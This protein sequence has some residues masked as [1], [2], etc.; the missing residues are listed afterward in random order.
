MTI[1]GKMFR[2]VWLCVLL[3]LC[4][5]PMVCSAQ[6]Y[7]DEDWI[8][9]VYNEDNGLPTG[10]ANA[11]VQTSDGYVWIGSYGGLIRFDGKEFLNF[12]ARK[13]LNSSSI[14][15]LYE[16]KNGILYIGTNDMGVYLY[17]KGVFSHAENSDGENSFYSV[18]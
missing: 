12:S 18:R 7:R 14:R 11:I 16:G 9:T 8:R 3:F 2:L 10:E 13:M 1:A 15:A 4:G 5:L 17:E 6:E